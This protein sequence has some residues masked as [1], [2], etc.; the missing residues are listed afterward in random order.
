MFLLIGVGE[1]G[2]S[3]VYCVISRECGAIYI[4]VSF[5]GATVQFVIFLY[6]E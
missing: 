6:G 2:G 1:E 4:N 3:G 5:K